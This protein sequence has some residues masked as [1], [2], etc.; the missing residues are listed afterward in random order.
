ET[1][2]DVRSLVG[3]TEYLR[4][5]AFS[6]DGKLLASGGGDRRLRIYDVLSGALKHDLPGHNLAINAVAFTPDGKRVASVAGDRVVRV[7]DPTPGAAQLAVAPFKGTI[8]AVTFHPD[9]NHVIVAG[10]DPNAAKLL[11]VADGSER[12]VYE[13]HGGPVTCVALSRDG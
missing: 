9:G 11:A 7:L 6:P 1:G 13:G 5:I 2:K 8:F 12:Q 3:H 10:A 4:G